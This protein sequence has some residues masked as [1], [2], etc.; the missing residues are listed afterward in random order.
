VIL[1]SDAV[2]LYSLLYPVWSVTCGCATPISSCL[3]PV[4]VKLFFCESYICYK[5]VAAPP[6]ELFFHPPVNM[7]HEIGQLIWGTRLDS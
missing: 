7:G 4:H 3:L 2:L 1:S 6:L 5:S